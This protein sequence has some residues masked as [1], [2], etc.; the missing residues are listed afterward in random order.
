MKIKHFIFL[1]V[2]VI[3]QLQINAQVKDLSG[4]I[5]TNNQDTIHGYLRDDIDSKLSN[6]V[7]FHH[8]L[9]EENYMIYTPSQISGF[10]FNTGRTFKSIPQKNDTAVEFGKEIVNGKIKM[11]MVRK[12]NSDKYKIFL[13]RSDTNLSVTLTAPTKKVIKSNGKTYNQI[14]EKYLALLSY[15][16]ENHKTKKSLNTVKFRD[17]DISKYIMQYNNDFEKAFPSSI[18][19]ENYKLTYDF[20]IGIPLRT[21]TGRT[22]F[23]FSAYRN[24]TR[25]EKTMNFSTIIGISYRYWG[26]SEIPEIFTIKNYTYYYRGHF[27]SIIPFGLSYQGNP[28]KVIPYAYAGIGLGIDI[29]NS[30]IISN[31]EINGTENDFYFTPVFN[32]AVGLKYKLKSSYIFTEITP[33]VDDGFYINLGYSF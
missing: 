14:N 13:V 5:I 26:E 11:Y 2:L 25:I 33:S 10:S 23:R 9:S 1:F 19:E 3:I 32:C 17:D 6:S 27:L 22:L 18:Y 7:E 28:R 12:K 20:A 16:T 29:T 30:Y 21:G 31:Y 24:K 4:Y 15:I 8:D